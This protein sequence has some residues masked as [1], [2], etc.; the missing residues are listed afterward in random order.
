MAS[1]FAIRN[2]LSLK[3]ALL[4][5]AIFGMALIA[6]LLVQRTQRE[7]LAELLASESRER[8]RMMAHVVEMTGQSLRDFIS[9]Y[10]E[11][12]ELVS[13]IAAPRRA[14][15]A[16][17]LDAS[18]G[19]FKLSAIWTLR[20]DGTV[21]YATRGDNPRAPPPDFPL[22]DAAR[23][24]VLA[25]GN[26]ASLFVQ[27][28]EGLLE[29]WLAPVHPSAGPGPGAEPRGWL[30]A[31]R[32]WDEAQLRL[33]GEVIQGEV[34]LMPPGRPLPAARPDQIALQHPLPGLD[35]SPVANLVYILRSDELA[36]VSR[37]QRTAFVVVA[38]TFVLTTLAA[39][40]FVFRWIV[41][42][43]DVIGRS[44]QARDAH[45]ILP[46]MGRRDE[47]GRVAQALKGS[48]E[49]HAALEES[50]EYRTRLG[51][52]LHDGVIQTVYAA[53]MNLAGARATLRHDPAE[54]E[55][56]MEDTRNELNSTISSLRAFI[57]GLEPEPTLRRTFREILQSIVTL[58]QGV[59]R[60]AVTL[61]V[62]DALAAALTEYQRQHLLQITREAVSNSV[63]HG[64]AKSLLIRLELEPAGAVMEITD[65]GI[66]LEG[67]APGL[68]GGRGLANLAARA[69]ELG[70]EL[71]VS[72]APGG[73]LRIRLVVPFAGAT[74]A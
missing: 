41:R 5:A 24:R 30:V 57:H 49:Q 62:D 17:N 12:D 74:G 19:T 8:S 38:A 31:A 6:L 36:I 42:P 65:D 61:Q 69:R 67:G 71:L 37:D 68:D 35:G 7:S 26:V 11:W 32:I 13:F 43:L 54:A 60:V 20:A 51:R 28:P 39:G 25:A 48:F 73:G 18:L 52:E 46:L 56:V 14:W 44:L 45:S 59:R 29:V 27:R 55:R 58:M 72:P 34:V 22:D 4:V 50:I 64:Q 1:P 66:G 63:R 2:N 10:S 53:G 15:A 47:I 33:L 16:I 9:D 21:V 70:S 3:F 40:Y 23:Q